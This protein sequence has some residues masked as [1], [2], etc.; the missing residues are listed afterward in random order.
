MA[1]DTSKILSQM[2]QLQATIASAGDAFGEMHKRLLDR[3]VPRNVANKMTQEASARFF[4]AAFN[5]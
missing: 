4:A 3:G 1:D 2:D 5:K